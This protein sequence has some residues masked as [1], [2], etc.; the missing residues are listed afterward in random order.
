MRNIDQKYRGTGFKGDIDKCTISNFKYLLRDNA[1]VDV[2]IN[3]NA[4]E[5]YGSILCKFTD[6]Y[7][8]TFPKM[9]V[10]I[11]RKNFISP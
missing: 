7:N 2:L 8:I 5:S 9:E 3:E 1:W 4:S 11:K 6:L 10:K